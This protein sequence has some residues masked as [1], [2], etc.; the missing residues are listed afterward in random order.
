MISDPSEKMILCIVFRCE[1]C[2]TDGGSYVDTVVHPLS[3]SGTSSHLYP[4]RLSG[5]VVNIFTYIFRAHSA[6][7]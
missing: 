5:K 3:S 7:L 6:N 4:T 1:S 2:G